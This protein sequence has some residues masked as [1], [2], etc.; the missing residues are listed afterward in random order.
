MIT[1]AL[2]F[3]YLLIENYKKLKM[4]EKE[5]ATILVMDQLINEGNRFVT[6]DLL[7]L[8]MTLDAKEID[9][10]F[11]KMLTKGYIVYKTVAKKTV[12]SLD[13]LKERL[14]HD[15]QITLSNETDEAKR[16]ET[17]NCLSNIYEQYEKLLNRPLSPVETSKIREWISYGYEDKMIV[18]ALKE[19]LNND[20]KSLRSVDNILLT[21]STRDD[22]E[23]EG[24]SP[25]SEDW[26]KDLQ[27]TIRIAKTPW[28]NKDDEDN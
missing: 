10:I 28:I 1:E 8:K 15:F 24:H 7:S 4:N 19:A 14:Y 5:L 6:V 3:R 27:E 26:D 17:E 2:D 12:T 9:E 22:R 18:D 11:A 20:K 16:N 13:P 25:I 23:N 21:W